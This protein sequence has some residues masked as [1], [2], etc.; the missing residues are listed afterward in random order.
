MRFCPICACAINLSLFVRPSWVRLKLSVR[1]NFSDQLTV[2]W[3]E[4]VQ[5][6]S[7]LS[8]AVRDD[9]VVLKMH[10]TEIFYVESLYSMQ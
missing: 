9:V 3:H 1:R 7:S 2:L 5:I 6:S 10:S 8:L 4:L